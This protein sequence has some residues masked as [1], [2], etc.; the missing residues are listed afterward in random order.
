MAS[1]P[2]SAMPFD[3]WSL[4]RIGESRS[5]AGAALYAPRPAMR[6]ALPIALLLFCSGACALV[7]QV[8]WL[9]EL[10][11]VFGSSTGASAEVL[12]IFMAGLGA[13]GVVLGRRVEREPRPLAF[14][15][16]LELLVALCAAVTPLLVSLAR[17][18]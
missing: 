1:A 13:G 12:A 14:Y 17:G 16:R 8:V 5:R 10:R 9:R 2:S 15:A 3:P 6:R 7:Y 4:H 11:L 18:V